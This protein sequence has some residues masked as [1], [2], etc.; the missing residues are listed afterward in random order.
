MKIKKFISLSL[1]GLLLFLSSGCD[2]LKKK[3]TTT[4]NP[5]VITLNYYKLFD[6]EDVFTPILQKFQSKYPHIRINYKKFN[7]F[8]EY[9]SLILNEMAE[10]EGPDIF[11]VQNTWIAKNTKKLT[12][13]K[14][15]L[16]T[17]ELA[18]QAFVDVAAKDVLHYDQKDG[19][20]KM[21]G[22]PLTVDTLALYYN[23]SHFEDALPEKG[24]PSATWEGLK[25]DVYRLTKK[26]NSFERF[27]RSGIAL[28]RSENISRSVDILYLMML[29]Y[30]VDF[31]NKDYNEAAF[32]KATGI[33]PTTPAADALDLYTSFA[34]QSNKNY[35]WN[36]Y[37]ASESNP[38]KELDAFVSG[39]LSMFVSYSYAYEQ[40][41]DLIKTK[42]AAGI[43]TIKETSVRVAPAP[44][45]FDP[46]VSPDKRTAY[47][48][49]FVEVVSRTSKHPDE[50]W[51]FLSFLASK[52]SNQHYFDKTH[53]PTS[54]R[55]LIEEQAKE[56]IYGVFVNQIGYAESFAIYD[57]ELYIDVFKQAIDAVIATGNPTSAIK[58]AER[59]ISDLLPGKGFIPLPP[60]KPP[61]NN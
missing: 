23:K 51:L 42:R 52:E 7:D 19:L 27:F 3:T 50:A 21:F 40:V 56:P 39:K 20:K 45:V 5:E 54:R 46:K 1:I 55:D 58:N 2:W 48:N 17:P 4:T 47:A 35:S 18:E 59:L 8:D 38:E 6:D 53:K 32:A 44:Q 31:Y 41:M 37:I 49:Y 60:P 13:A 16:I 11:S 10:G 36:K 29:Q 33:P 25:E 30:K 9:N 57:R 14:L 24:A 61:V 15:T 28:G 43:D 34:L 26:D 12:P 22:V